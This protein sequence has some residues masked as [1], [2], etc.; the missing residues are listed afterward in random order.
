MAALVVALEGLE[1]LVIGV[2]CLPEV[3]VEVGAGALVNR[4]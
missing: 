3:K 4:R 2:E 1:C